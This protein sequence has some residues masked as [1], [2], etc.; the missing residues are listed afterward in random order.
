MSLL[1][2]KNCSGVFFYSNKTLTFIKWENF[3]DDN[4]I[5]HYTNCY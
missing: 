3:I 1:Q 4:E 5:S 2:C